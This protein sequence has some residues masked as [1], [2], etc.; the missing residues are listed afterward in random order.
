MMIDLIWAAHPAWMAALTAGYAAA[1]LWLMAWDV[2]RWRLREFSG[3]RV[4]LRDRVARCA[5]S[6]P[7]ILGLGYLA[8]RRWDRTCGCGWRSVQRHRIAHCLA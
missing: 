4:I 2:Q 1:L 3:W 5:P 8:R 7:A 6:S